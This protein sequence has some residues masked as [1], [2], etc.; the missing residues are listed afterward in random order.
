LDEV[1]PP[2]AR[3]LM[4]LLAVTVFVSA[5]T[6][7]FQT[8][9]LDRFA[10]EF[11][12]TPA[13]IGWVPTLTFAGFLA[14]IVFLVPLGDRVDKRRLILAHVAGLTVAVLAMAGAPSLQVL[15]IASFEF[16]F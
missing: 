14:G 13:A 10:R 2:R 16:G 11:A 7:H 1:H 6:V 8:P 9:M 15:L 5:T 3:G 4:P 12:A